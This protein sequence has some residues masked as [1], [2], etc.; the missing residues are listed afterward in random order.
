MSLLS[1]KNQKILLNIRLYEE[2]SEYPV[3]NPQTTNLF[4]AK[5][6]YRV[7][8]WTLQQ[9]YETS[10]QRATHNAHAQIAESISD[11]KLIL[12]RT[13]VF[14]SYQQLLLWLLA[15]IRE[16]CLE[17]VPTVLYR[18]LLTGWTLLEEPLIVQ[19]LRISWKSKVQYRVHKSPPLVPILG[20]INPIHTIP[21]DEVTGFLYWSNPSS[22]TTALG[23]TQPLREMSTRN[24]PGM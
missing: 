6:A 24:L 3:H 20:H 17:A 15:G 5:Q 12:K 8:I 21:S 2:T 10:V 13:T 7:L 1:G 11:W 9:L 23:S 19:L 4:R 16:P 18:N 22:R 14:T